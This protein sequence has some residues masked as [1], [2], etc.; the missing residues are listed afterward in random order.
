LAEKTNNFNLSEGTCTG[1]EKLKKY[2]N[3]WGVG[4]RG[5][6]NLIQGEGSACAKNWF[7]VQRLNSLVVLYIFLFNKLETS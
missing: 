3:N 2:S 1:P 5:E 4:G 7:G 6:G